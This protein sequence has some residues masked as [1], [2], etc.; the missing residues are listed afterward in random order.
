MAAP[1][2]VSDAIKHCCGLDLNLDSNLPQPSVFCSGGGSGGDGG[3][4]GHMQS[5]LDEG[6][7]LFL[8]R[9]QAKESDTELE[10]VPQ[11]EPEVGT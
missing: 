7:H 9:R 4:L 1:S 6:G 3:A 11:P 10:A 5:V 2:W 8:V